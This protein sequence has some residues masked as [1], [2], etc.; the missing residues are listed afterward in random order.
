MTYPER[1]IGRPRIYNEIIKML[2][3]DELYTPAV[4]AQFAEAHDMLPNHPQT[5]EQ[6]RLAKQRIRISMIRYATIR[7]FQAYS[8]GMVK[9]KGQAPTPGWFGW[10]WIAGLNDPE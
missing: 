7:N 6:I 1:P 10:R 3:E 2:R 5:P 9:L 4:I 8:D